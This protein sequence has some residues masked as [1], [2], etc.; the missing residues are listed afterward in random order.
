MAQIPIQGKAGLPTTLVVGGR[1]VPVLLPNA[2]NGRTKRYRLGLF[3]HSYDGTALS[4]LARYFA[5]S[6][7]AANWG[8]GMVV[9]LP[10]GLPD[11]L[12]HKC[13]NS[14]DPC[15]A[16]DFVGPPNDVTFLR[17]LLILAMQTYAIDPADVV[18]FGYSNGAI[19]AYT[20]AL[21]AP[22]IVTSVY[23]FA[24]FCAFASDT[25]YCGDSGYKV[26]VTHITPMSDLVIA[27]DGD[28]TGSNVVDKPTGAY[29][30]RTQSVA[31]FGTRNGCTGSFAQYDSQDFTSATAGAET[32]RFRWSSPAASGS[33]ELWEVTG[34][35]ADHNVGMTTNFYRGVELRHYNCRRTA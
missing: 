3:L 19:M 14:A 35:L 27:P 34:A 2:Y 31:L 29:A 13:W 28:P 24:G 23:T 8:K 10:E 16:A 6:A 21:C 4:V 12:N 1:S 25:H 17:N 15:C 20:L 9:L 7:E 22:D 32:N 11:S 30:S 33:V 18:V 26:H 5:S